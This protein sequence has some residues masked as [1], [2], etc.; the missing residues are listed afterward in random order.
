[1][2]LKDSPVSMTEIDAYVKEVIAEH[3][4]AFGQSLDPD[5][6]ITYIMGRVMSHFKGG[7]NP[8]FL[9][10]LVMLRLLGDGAVT[11]VLNHAMQELAGMR[12]YCLGDA[13]INAR[14]DAAELM[15]ESFIESKH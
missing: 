5:A 6:T 4:L 8:V 2:T 1:M 12:D 7:L 10:P 11:L 13:K 9:R 3:P 15:I 14:L